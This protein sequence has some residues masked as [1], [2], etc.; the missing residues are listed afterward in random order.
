MIDESSNDGIGRK[1]VFKVRGTIPEDGN[2][3]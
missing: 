2:V 1:I 3:S